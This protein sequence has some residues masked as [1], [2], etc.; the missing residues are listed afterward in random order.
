MPETL[1][2]QKCGGEAGFKR[3]LEKGELRRVKQDGM[4]FYCWRELLVDQT[5]GSSRDRI[6]TS[7]T[8]EL[9]EKEYGNLGLETDQFDAALESAEFHAL[10]LPQAA[11][12]VHAGDLA[13][14]PFLRRGPTLALAD[15]TAPA[16]R[17]LPVH[18]KEKLSDAEDL[19]K[20]LLAETTKYLQTAVEPPTRVGQTLYQEVQDRGPSADV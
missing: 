9:T 3:A 20:R 15:S 11:S 17:T 7:G 12:S 6:G 5:T 16:P 13:V 10:A 2:I 18:L 4:E 1:A 19:T 8:A 14:N